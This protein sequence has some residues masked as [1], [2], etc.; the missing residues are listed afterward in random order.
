MITT[1][2]EWYG[3]NYKSKKDENRRNKKGSKIV[4]KVTENP[5]SKVSENVQND[6]A[7]V[8][9]PTNLTTKTKKHR[10]HSRGVGMV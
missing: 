4:T 10:R 7:V 5:T 2:I 9:T 1:N 6:T 3:H 8:V